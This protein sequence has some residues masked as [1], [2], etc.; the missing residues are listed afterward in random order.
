ML[1]TSVYL[2]LL[3]KCTSMEL[4][5][6]SYMIIVEEFVAKRVM[7]QFNKI[8]MKT[9]GNK[10]YANVPHLVFLN[11]YC[12]P[13]WCTHEKNNFA[14]KVGFATGT[15]VPG[16][17]TVRPGPGI[18]MCIPGT[19]KISQNRNFYHGLQ[20]ETPQHVTFPPTAYNFN[21]AFAFEF[22]KLIAYCASI[23]TTHCH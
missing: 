2:M 12:I 14:S 19:R 11:I 8:E 17:P 18:E 16:Y 21:L 22:M 3:I 20:N 6:Q 13:L 1:A 23:N 4:S 10:F 9:C 7:R 15:R 5:T